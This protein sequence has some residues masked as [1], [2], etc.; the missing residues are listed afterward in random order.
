MLR[1]TD[2]WVWDFWLADEG[3]SY[4]L[5]FL[6]APRHI[7]HPD[8]RHHN[9]SIGQSDPRWYEQLQDAL[10]PGEAWRDPWVFADP[11]G[12][13]WH[14]LVT[15]MSARP[16]HQTRFPG[17]FSVGP[18]SAPD[19]QTQAGVEMVLPCPAEKPAAP[20]AKGSRPL[21]PDHTAPEVSQWHR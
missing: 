12:D 5:Y 7:G 3:R 16:G 14:M 21:I 17:R 19:R 20:A 8:E 6:Q 13:G 1:L 2:A 11:G 4:H 9:V 10:W 18:L 15:R